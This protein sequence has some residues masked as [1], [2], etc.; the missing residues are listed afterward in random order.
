MTATS[1]DARSLW[2]THKC[3]HLIPNEDKSWREEQKDSTT[4]EEK[5]NLS[6]SENKR[7]LCKLLQ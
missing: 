5:V 7:K 3:E 2:D 6:F 1:E 4:A